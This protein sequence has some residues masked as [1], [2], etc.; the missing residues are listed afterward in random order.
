MNKLKLF[1]LSALLS[2]GALAQQVAVATLT[3]G[4]TAYNVLANPS[5]ISSFTFT[6][7]STNPAVLYLFDSATTTTNYVQAAYTGTTTYATNWALVWTNESDIV[8][9]NTFVGTWT[10]PTTVSATTNTLPVLAAAV[11]PGNGQSVRSVNINT[12]RGITAVAST[13]G[14]LQINYRR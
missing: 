11:A 12:T 14:I 6:S 1:I 4:G 7:T 9:T 5:A 3:T 10:G 2:F 13:P 8:I